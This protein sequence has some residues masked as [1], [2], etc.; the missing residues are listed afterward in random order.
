[1]MKLPLHNKKWI[2]TLSIFIFFLLGNFNNLNAQICNAT[3]VITNQ[4]ILI[5]NLENR[6]AI[7]KVYDESLAP[8]FECSSLSDPCLDPLL[9]ELNDCGTYYI[10]IQTFVNWRAKY[11]D[12]FEEINVA[13][14]GSSSVDC[15]A[16]NANIGDPCDDGDPQTANDKVQADC[17]CAG[18]VAPPTFDCPAINA[19]I[20]DPC[21][22]GDPQ[23]AND[24]VQ[25]DCSC[26][27]SVAPPTF[28]CPT[29]N[30]NIG[31]PCDDGNAVSTNDMILTGC[32]C[33]GTVI[34]P[35]FDCPALS[36]DIGDF[37]DDEN[38]L[39]SNDIVQADCSCSG[40]LAPPPTY[41][42][43]TLMANI[44]GSCDDGNPNTINDI[45]LADCS[46]VGTLTTEFNLA[47]WTFENCDP[48]LN[49]DELTANT[50]VPNGFNSV[51]ASIFN[52]TGMHSCNP[53]PNLNTGNTNN[54]ICHKIR[55]YCF[56]TNNSPDAYTFSITVDPEP[57]QALY[58]SKL[59][60]FE[61]APD[62]YEWLTGDTGPNN[63]PT[64]Y[65]WR[66]LRNG[67]E[68]G[69][70]I[71]IP[72]SSD[73]SFEE[74]DFSNLNIGAGDCTRATYTF[75]LLGYCEKDNGADVSIW[76]IDE[77]Q[78]YGFAATE[79]PLT[80]TRSAKDKSVECDG[81][82]NFVEYENW[83]ASNGG[84]TV[85]NPY[86][87]NIVWTNNGDNAF[88][89]ICGSDGFAK[90]T[91]T[92]TDE[93]GRSVD[94]DAI[95][96]VFD[97]KPPAFGF[98]PSDVTIECDDA[99]PTQAVIAADICGGVEIKLKERTKPG[100]CPNA[101]TI[102]KEWT[103]TDECGN[104]STATQIVTIQDNTP[105]VF[106][107]I[108]ANVTISCD[109]PIP[110]DIPTYS[111]NC[112]DVN[113][114]IFEDEVSAVPGF[115]S[116]QQTITKTW[117][118]TDPCG[119]TARATQTITVV[120][121]DAPTL[122]GVPSSVAQDCAIALPPIPTVTAT[123]NC[124]IDP[125][126]IFNEIN[127]PTNCGGSI[128]RTW[129]T[130][131]DCGNTI[132]Q[133]QEITLIDNT[134]PNITTPAMDLT[135]E[136]NVNTNSNDLI[137]WL[138]SN[139][140]A[141]A[142][143]DCSNFGWSHDFTGVLTGTCGF[144]S[145]VDVTFTATDV[146]GNSSS[147]TARFTSVDNTPPTIMT[148]ATN[149]SVECDGAGNVGSI[150]AWL[151]GNGGATAS[152]LCSN[153]VTWTNNYNGLTAGCVATGSA[154]VTFTATDAC[155]LTAQTTAMVEIVDTQAPFFT[156]PAG[157]LVVDCNDPT[158]NTQ[159]QDWL[160][161]NGGAAAGDFCSTPTFTNNY[162][163]NNLPA[164]CGNTTVQFTA[165]DDCGN[166]SV[167]GAL[168][169]VQNN[170]P[171]VFTTLPV[172]GSSMCEPLPVGAINANTDFTTWLNNNNNNIAAN[173]A[174]GGGTFITNNWNPFVG[175]SINC[176]NNP[177]GFIEIIW[178]ATDFCG[179]TT[180]TSAT[181]TVTPAPTPT[182]VPFNVVSSGYN[183]SSI[184][185]KGGINHFVA[186]LRER[187]VDLNW[188]N[189]TGPQNDYF[190]IERSTDGITF[191]AIGE[192]ENLGVDE[193]A[194]FYQQK[195][196][197]P[198]I[199]E[200]YYRL[201]THYLDG[202]HEYSDIRR[203]KI[204]DI[205]DFGLFPNPAQEEVNIS[206]KGYQDRDITIQMVDHLGHVL[207]EESIDGTL[208]QNHKISLKKYQNG[209]YTIW[210]FADKRRPIGKKLIVN[211]MY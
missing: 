46:C 27:G 55:P 91:F 113:D 153:N 124:D 112:T 94:T 49:Y 93:C 195:D 209:F 175:F 105:P 29:I 50:N 165:T 4:D 10:Q 183:V 119:N 111:D 139:G 75:E 79:E 42:C 39:T 151:A 164:S 106:E 122:S 166:S 11:C 58:I 6:R 25:A 48:G 102:T 35:S 135:I 13:G 157:N 104:K 51:T 193:S 201:K 68:I 89:T 170:Q 64:K 80:I 205:E 190:I 101:S 128:V 54:A 149:F 1:M 17:S 37:C 147:T 31:D 210:V 127:I 34:S 167:I 52:S 43:P 24:K 194:I 159:I 84:A 98:I 30:A 208:N 92:A 73:W 36:A 136:C 67:I 185:K 118:I 19:N 86:N 191:E 22:D 174:C 156:A 125:Q 117:T 69:R 207:Y 21:D 197:S 133:S 189:N 144:S 61:K 82:G 163:P 137:N 16:L 56:W 177:S 15:P 129:T 97:T 2:S 130:S 211:R 20:G 28:D 44:G 171:P 131:D 8:V 126:V 71:D 109:A 100:S 32:I 63:P 141:M 154:M 146:C 184:S 178:T 182:P 107:T 14:C 78:I 114:I 161:S 132:S 187:V 204:S 180:T 47:H 74:F 181:F 116:G 142:A 38:A 110:T 188:T 12:I 53:G 192:Y 168:I 40:T 41:D 162:D 143:D 198:N 7:I 199:G 72:T 140:G 123:D 33:A 152:D 103:V 60:F 26:A 81:Q 203:I 186:T 134:A 90:V 176:N 23:T 145:F 121:N 70:Q 155:G 87:H 120:D 57:G 59:T 65:G 83:L 9:I 150:N 62:T 99:L 88:E 158:F 202:T 77:V 173:D 169:V 148:P 85:N 172:N 96:S 3:Y 138:T 18:S 76:D 206:L 115:C 160:D 179:N 108:P 5:S 196:D 95:F 66:V 45:A 200:N